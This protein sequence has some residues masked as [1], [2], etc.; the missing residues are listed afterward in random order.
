[1]EEQQLYF[2]PGQVVTLK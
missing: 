2:V 1:M